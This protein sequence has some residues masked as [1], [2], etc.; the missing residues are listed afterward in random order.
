MTQTP[1]LETRGLTK[2]FGGL[3]ATDNVNLQLLGTEL[4]A[5]IG[6]NGAGKSTLIGQLSGEIAPSAGT[7]H[8]F[9]NDVSLLGVAQRANLGLARSYQI[10]QV[11]KELSTFD[12]V[13][14]AALARGARDGTD[15]PGFFGRLFSPL[16]NNRVLKDA[17]SH[18][19]NLVGLET[20]GD[21]PC[22]DLAHGEQRQLEIAMALALEP[23]LLLL[24]EPLAGMSK[25]ESDV[26][27]ELLL[28]LKGH[29]PILLIEHDMDA[30]FALA[31][32][33]SVLVY[34]A[35]IATDKPAVVRTNPAVRA[36]YLGD[37][38][39]PELT[40]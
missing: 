11:C 13:L 12:N 28:K 38:A 34:G 16:H 40:V 29:Y 2:R 10:S 6:P 27:V 23:K 32:R 37:E 21:T 3:T 17:A 9:G 31:D 4:H 5:I 24:D 25:A 19:L 20:R 14:M 1:V 39:A 35:I 18:A 15:N 8:F 22:A 36:A 7:I 30:V 26:M 33:V